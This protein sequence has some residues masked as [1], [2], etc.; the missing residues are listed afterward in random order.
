MISFVL[1]IKFFIYSTELAL[2]NSGISV[3]PPKR[4]RSATSTAIPSGPPTITSSRAR[5][6]DVKSKMLEKE[7][8][9]SNED[10]QSDSD[11]SDSDEEESSDEDENNDE[12]K[13]SE[14]TG[15][16]IGKIF[17][18]FCSNLI[19]IFLLGYRCV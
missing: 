13:S 16:N 19:K 5:R 1:L 14:D 7:D 6:S 15:D 12:N 11:E 9:S 17:I 8:T 2:D 18:I 4:S 10:N 3:A